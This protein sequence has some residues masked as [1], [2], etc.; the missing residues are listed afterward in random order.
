M[1]ESVR[2]H[3]SNS[4][5]HIVSGILELLA[6]DLRSDC[7]HTDRHRQVTVNAAAGTLPVTVS[8]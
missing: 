7:T 4:L 1:K 8:G 5:T 2:K 3:F 6:L